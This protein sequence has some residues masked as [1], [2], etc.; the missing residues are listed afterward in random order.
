MAV[1]QPFC[2]VFTISLLIC[3]TTTAERMEKMT[4]EE[5][6]GILHEKVGGEGITS[7][8]NI[9]ELC[10]H[11]NEFLMQLHNSTLIKQ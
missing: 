5:C 7:L 9:Y 3:P 11:C 8:P 2:F 6:L 10:K 1:L 4:A